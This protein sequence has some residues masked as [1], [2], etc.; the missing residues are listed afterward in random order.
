MY[1]IDESSFRVDKTSFPTAEEAEQRAAEA[2]RIKGQ[3][4]NVYELIGGELHFAFRVMPDGSTENENPLTDPASG[5]MIEPATEVAL[6]SREEILDQ[7]AESLETIGEVDLAAAVDRERAKS[8]KKRP[9]HKGVAGIAA[10][11]MEG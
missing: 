6:S 1:V 2:A 9:P 3:A 11:L 4:V 7:V 10:K 8:P 5:D